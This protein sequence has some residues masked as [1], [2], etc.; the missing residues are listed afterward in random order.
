[1]SK[2]DR[3]VDPLQAVPKEG[4]FPFVASS[5]PV[6]NIYVKNETQRRQVA[7]GLQRLPK[8]V[9]AMSRSEAAARFD[10]DGGQR[11]GDFVL[12]C[13]PGAS[14]SS[15]SRKRDRRMPHGMHGYDPLLQD[16]GGIFYAA[17]PHFP[18]GKALA[19]VR[20]VDITP[21]VCACLGISPPSR[22][23]GR[24]LIAAH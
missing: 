16:M 12:L 14:F 13:P 22:C 4:Y 10:Y 11:T 18:A 3:I 6:C 8:D 20:A 19:E 9:L 21:T 5:G 2:V 7:A 24:N 1:M 17:G 15:F 23:E